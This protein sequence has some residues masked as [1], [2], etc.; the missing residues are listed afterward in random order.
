M[1]L[2]PKYRTEWFLY[3]KPQIVCLDGATLYPAESPAWDCL[4]MLGNCTIHDR[5]AQ[6]EITKRASKAEILLTNKVPVSAELIKRLPK[7]RYIGVLATGY[8]IVDTAAAKTAGITVTNIPAYSTMSVAQHTIALMMAVAS[9]I[10]DYSATVHSGD[11]CR[12]ND[13]SYR[14]FNWRELAGKTFGIV[15]LGN[16]GSAVA[17]IAYA[18]GMKIAVATSKPKEDL[19]TGYT[20][21]ELDELFSNADIVSLH[22]PLTADNIGLVDKRRLS[23][24]KQ[25]AILLNTARGPLIDESA[26]EEALREHRI[27]GAAL[28]VLC[29]EPPLDNCPLLNAPNCIITPHIAWASQEARERLMNIAEQNIKA[30]LSGRPQNVVNDS[31]QRG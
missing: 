30:F 10:E 26:L 4:R 19:P 31:V 2:R 27:A 6:D 3:M 20:K 13:F 24:M 23:L 16:I 8:N 29:N 25:D 28:D 1:P 14:L 18:M 15:G 5:T 11:W 21:M 12:C 9:R 22:C 17:R 7:L